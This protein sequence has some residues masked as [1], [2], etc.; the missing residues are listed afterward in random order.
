VHPV[1]IVSEAWHFG[2]TH[3]GHDWFSV[4]ILDIA[5]RHLRAL[6]LIDLEIRMIK[7]WNLVNGN[8]ASSASHTN[9]QTV[10]P[11]LVLHANSSDT[12]RRVGCHLDGS[13]ATSLVSFLAQL[14]SAV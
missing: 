4:I 11:T 6:V 12:Y 3:L 7:V 10:E 2:F 8:C 1:N 5:E 14:R 9:T 13:E